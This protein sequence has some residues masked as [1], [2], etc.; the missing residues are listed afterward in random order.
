[1]PPVLSL[2]TGVTCQVDQSAGTRCRNDFRHQGASGARW[3]AHVTNS[4]PP[5]R[6]VSSRQE[7]GARGVRP[8]PE[9]CAESSDFFPELPRLVVA[10]I[11]FANDL[12]MPVCLAN[13]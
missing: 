7:G 11:A 6:S 2:P 3:L 13:L 8:S 1:M 10:F 4:R 9:F 12:Q 5:V